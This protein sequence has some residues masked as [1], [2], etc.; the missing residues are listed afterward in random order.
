MNQPQASFLPR[1]Q[2]QNLSGTS[3]STLTK[4]AHVSG[5]LASSLSG[6]LSVTFLV[7][8]LACTVMAVMQFI[9]PAQGPERHLYAPLGIIL[10]V[11]CLR[12]AGHSLPSDRS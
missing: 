1:H 4:G 9:D 8:G 2:Q 5:S 3:P 10:M 11:L 6:I 7:L 12:S